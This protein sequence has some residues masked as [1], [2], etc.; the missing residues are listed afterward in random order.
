MLENTTTERRTGPGDTVALWVFIAAGAAV[1]V[2][3]GVSS[4]SRLTAV[5]SGT[6][7]AMATTTFSVGDRLRRETDGLV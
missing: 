6:P 2:M 7:L 1:L 3:S 4:V 5:L